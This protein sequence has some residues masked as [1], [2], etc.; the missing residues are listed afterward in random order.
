[1]QIHT[2]LISLLLAK[3]AH[4]CNVD[5]CNATALNSLETLKTAKF[6]AHII[7]IVLKIIVD[8]FFQRIIEATLLLCVPVT[9]VVAPARG[10]EVEFAQVIGRAAAAVICPDETR[11]TLCALGGD[12]GRYAVLENE[13]LICSDCARVWR[14]RL[15]RRRRLSTT[16]DTTL[17]I[18]IPWAVT[19]VKF[20]AGAAVVLDI[21]AIT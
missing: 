1:M 11:R 3:L 19:G 5:I 14:G 12:E 6:L 13:L 15:W 21:S 8:A 18:F 17:N 7:Q 9:E 16:L 4:K 20:S 10:C 2:H